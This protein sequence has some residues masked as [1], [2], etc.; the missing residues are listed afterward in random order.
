MASTSQQGR[1]STDVRALAFRRGWESF[2]LRGP[3]FEQLRQ[4]STSRW[5][6]TAVGSD[7][8]WPPQASKDGD[9]LMFVHWL[10]GG[11]GNLF[12][13]AAPLLSNSGRPRLRDG[14]R[15]QLALT[16]DGLH[17]PARTAIN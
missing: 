13:C 15:L 16:M 10:F 8:G 3:S 9:Q 7:D 11:V 6:S 12:P 17:K 1:R 2:P 4:A 5:P 14:L